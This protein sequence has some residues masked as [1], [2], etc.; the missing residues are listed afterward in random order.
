MLLVI[1][2]IVLHL[3]AAA[4]KSQISNA[5]PSRCFS[6][7]KVKQFLEKN[8]AARLR[9]K[10]ALLNTK[11][12]PAIAGNT[13][14]RPGGVN[15]IINIP[16]IFHIVLADPYIITDAG[17]QSQI[18]ELNKD[19]AGLN[20]DSVN[21]P[22]FYPVRGHSAIIRFVLAK[23]TPAG[24][25][26]NGV[27]RIVSST[28]SNANLAADPI[29][30]SALG[31]ADA[32]N[33]A[34]YL[35]IW[36]GD[37]ISGK[38]ILGYAQFPEAGLP[39]DDGVFCNYKSFGVSACNI[40]LYNKGRTLCHEIGHYLG[41][42]HIW[43]DEDACTGDDFRSL[44]A[45][46]SAVDLPSDLYNTVADANTVTDI[47]DTPNQGASSSGC[48]SGVVTDACSNIAP[49]KMY[50]NYMDYTADNCY[51]LFTKKQVERMEWVLQN[52]RPGLVNSLG[53]IA[54]AGA[55]T[56]DV[57][58]I[59]SVNPGIETNGCASII[60]PSFLN[61]PG[62]IIPKVRI[63]NNGGDSI[64]SLKVGLLVNG[65]AKTPVSITIPTPGLTFGATSVVSFPALAVTT[66]TYVLKF[67]TFNAN[68]IIVDQDPLNDTLTTTLQVSDGVTLPADEDFE[69]TT[70][71]L[72]TWSIY[73]PDGDATWAKT[74]G[75]N[76]SDGAIF[77]DN[78]TKNNTGLKDELRTPKFLVA[79]A[80]SIIV[81][82]DL[83]H[84][85]YPGRNDQLS[86]LV[87]NN[88]GS[89]WTTVYT[90]S[91]SNL[92]TAGSTT[93]RY[94]S[95]AAGDWKPQKITIGGALLS[96]GKIIIAFQN[97]GDYGNNIF[98]D[99][100]L[101]YKQR[102]LD[103]AASA[104]LSPADPDCS[105]T[106]AV[107]QV[108]VINN[109]IQTLT[110]FTVGYIL[111]S[112]PPVYQSFTDKI[113]PGAS[114][115]VELNPLTAAIGVNDITIFTTGAKSSVA[116]GDEN[117]LNDTLS[118]KFTINQIVKPPLNEGFEN[119]TFAP[120]N[121]QIINPDNSTTWQRKAPGSGSGFSAFMDNFTDD[122][123]GAADILK[124]PTIAVAGADSVFI[125]FDLAYKNF[126]GA[127]DELLVKVS[128]D[129][130]N[131][132]TTV[133]DKSGTALATAGSSASAYLDPAE[134]DWKT[135]R[136]AL[137]NVYARENIIV[138]FEN[139]SDYGNNIFIDNV[140]VSALYKRDVSITDIRVPA[141][142]KCNN[143]PAIP[144]VTITNTGI[145]TI[146]AF[147]ILYSLD[148][149]P[150]VS[151]L[152][153][154]LSLPAGTQLTVPLDAFTA[155]AG[156]HTFVAYTANL[157]TVGGTG[158]YDNLNDTLRR[159]FTVLG[160][161]P[162]LPLTQGFEGAV[163]PPYSWGVVNNNDSTK[164]I[165]VNDAAY[166][167][168]SSIM[169]H[170]FNDSL[171]NTKSSL[172]TPVIINNKNNDSVFVSFALA[173]RQ[174]ENDGGS[175]TLPLDTLEIGLSQDCGQT[176]QTIWKKWGSNLVTVNDNNNTPTGN[177]IPSKKDWKIFNC[178][179]SPFTGSGNFQL[180]FIA[181]GNQ[182]NNIW[183]DD[184]NVY[185]KQL[186]AKLKEQGYLIY[187]NP[188]DNSFLIHHFAV[189]SNLKS[190]E[191]Y[192]ASGKLTYSRRYESN[193]NTE[194]TV[195]LQGKSA[196]VCV[197]KMLYTNKTVVQ[198]IVKR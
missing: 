125:S 18:S 122:F 60:N 44:A 156:N 154:G 124:T 29:K 121:W 177:F 4:Q 182:Q 135:Q 187:P 11:K 42:F 61:C 131:S 112:A 106:V 146:T 160:T 193:A 194:I 38:S 87:S 10:R 67:F 176:M 69:S 82:F 102:K 161:Q 149:A 178:Y 158:D 126:A 105:L 66:G 132:F 98:I 17:I 57:S 162:Y 95:P 45:T 109:G 129:C 37:D 9:S 19:Y 148:N 56:R 96:T 28:G 167:G 48:L 175:T 139:I 93:L 180:Y 27:E 169:I 101:I 71:P 39:Q 192:D 168:S 181:K 128:A 136:I 145:D 3:L 94:N 103:I 150:A 84:K 50:Q 151:K 179:L 119:T 52:A 23:Q 5:V 123:T 26:T 79:P 91:G 100:I 13:G 189:P 43:G 163:F 118:K 116:E 174:G 65:V 75:G 83:A 183:L 76:N 184:I 97:K 170:N 36:V 166:S 16:V 68:G 33:A 49:G 85:N 127:S 188:F 133:F 81:S 191:V 185:A 142:V 59:A 108:T 20:A 35:N 114:A 111:N 24:T 14:H 54:P 90:K 92:A 25:A 159:S 195:S 46:G 51:S 107:P 58:P 80:D 72:H 164:W 110:S 196:G 63:R 88:C 31:G 186:P 153:E 147:T 165:S 190:I 113:L 22:N 8:P 21:A 89:S 1:V 99:N 130:G 55:V 74:S 32:W 77:I 70:F 73:N 53:A 6:M 173:Y 7:E 134:E 104:I 172:I 86:I 137:D 140:H 2:G 15:D 152:F 34:S 144:E 41:L 62:S 78:F 40:S 141:I 138:E 115:T 12:Q 47:G 120:P 64:T 171:G 143:G 30:R 198:K 117:T 197:L 155:V 157:V